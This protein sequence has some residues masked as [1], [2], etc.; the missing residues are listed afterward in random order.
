MNEKLM[1]LDD[2]NFR[3]EVIDAELPVLVDFWAEWCGPC[4]MIAPL[5]EE[6]AEEFSGRIKFCQIN[7]EKAQ[8]TTG[9]Y[10]IMN[11]PTILFFNGG[12][13]VDKAV[14]VLPK[15]TIAKKIQD[16]L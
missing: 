7:V 13:M 1:A 12:E 5:I 11:I 4:K 6:L 10:S 3:S 16:L 14:G 9:E 2:S 8:E 15:E